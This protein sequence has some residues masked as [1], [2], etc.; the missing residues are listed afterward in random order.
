[1]LV[2]AEQDKRA[3]MNLLRTQKDATLNQI[4]ELYQNTVKQLKNERKQSK[5][6]CKHNYIYWLC[7]PCQYISTE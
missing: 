2:E 6:S 1:M 4:R 3:A 5:R 7:K